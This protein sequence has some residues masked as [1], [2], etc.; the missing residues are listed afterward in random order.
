MVAV[1]YEDLREAFDFVGSGAPMEH[2]AFISLETAA[3]YW[4]SE[5]NPLDEE[6]P[7]DLETSNRYIT[8][9]HKNDLDLGA[10]S[11]CA[12]RQR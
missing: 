3:I 4:I 9:P 12:S 7:D 11:P 5:M 2:S 10:T 1:K 6:V 8:V